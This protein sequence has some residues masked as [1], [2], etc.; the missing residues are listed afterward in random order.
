MAQSYFAEGL[1]QREATFSLFARSLP[2]GW[3]Y[4]VAA[5]L[6]DALSYLEGFAFR[7][8]DIAYLEQ[9]GLFTAAFLE[10]LGGVRFDGD[11]RAMPEGTVFFPGEPV[12]ELSGGVLVAQ[13]VETV[14][15]NELHFQSLIASKAARSVDV[16]GGRTLVDFG[17]RRTHRADAGMR[18]ARSSFL[19]GFDSTSNVL[20]GKQ[21]GIPLA[22]TM[23]HSYVQCFPDELTAFRAFAR[24]F[25]DR[26][27]LLVDTYDTIEGVRR[28][29]AVARELADE[30]HRLV[31][32]R[33]DSGDLAA[34]SLAARRMLDD[35]GATDAIVFAS[36]GLDE[37]DVH[38]LVA[39]GAPI[40][41]FGIGSRMAT[42]ADASYLDMAYKLVEFDGRPVLKL[43]EEKETLPGPKQ[44]WRCT[45]GGRLAFD[46]VGLAGEDDPEGGDPLLEVVMRGGERLLSESLEQCRQRCAA[47]RALLPP[48]VRSLDA[49]TYEVE[50]TRAVVGLRD[51]VVDE[52]SR[53]HIRQAP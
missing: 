39:S 34:L 31:G 25:P 27:I 41:G 10:H 4:F 8:E 47:Q 6:D 51:E 21:Y 5:G 7:A 29:A 16:A 13:L 9:T 52:L 44:V 12:L 15:L 18:A 24:S 30:G 32:V 50:L 35:A 3:G 33:L 19:A 42:A 46:A 45:V 36:G 37:H 22:G 17:L 38:R 2:P 43:S 14:A 23:A 49:S 20:A 1:H 26:T 53:G 28:A 40:D 11:V 48:E